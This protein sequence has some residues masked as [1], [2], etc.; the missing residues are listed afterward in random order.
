MGENIADLGGLTMAFHAYKMTDEFKS[1]KIVNGFN[2]AQR[3]FIAY[4]QLWKIKYTDEE[5]KNRIAN[6][7]HSPGMYRVNGPLM[8]C[9]EF[10][11]AF[12]VKESDAMRNEELKVS[13]I[14]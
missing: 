5:M 9:P 11:E 4:A 14:W 1:G 8:N 7:S 2:P 10:F 3:F 12:D 13:R 6:D